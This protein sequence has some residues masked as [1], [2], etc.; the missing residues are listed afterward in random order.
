MMI[1]KSLYT[2][3]LDLI[4]KKVEKSSRII[5]KQANERASDKSEPRNQ[6]MLSPQYDSKLNM[7][8]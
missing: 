7:F 2:I 6:N 1:K 4:E 5:V 8:S 3:E